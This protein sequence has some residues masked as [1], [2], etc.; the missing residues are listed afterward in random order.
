MPRNLFLLRTCYFITNRVL[1]YM[2]YVNEYG[3]APR[4]SLDETAQRQDGFRCTGT[5]LLLAELSKS[6][7]SVQLNQLIPSLYNTS[8]FAASI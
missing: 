3:H 4:S 2:N 7:N 6:R 1:I 5:I 8:S